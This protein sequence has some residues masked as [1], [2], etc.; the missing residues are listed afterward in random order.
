MSP[1]LWNQFQANSSGN[2]NIS[3]KIVID[4]L[5]NKQG[6]I[7]RIDNELFHQ[8]LLMYMCL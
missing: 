2:K 7:W 4:V 8:Q 3:G 1:K 6:V 5:E